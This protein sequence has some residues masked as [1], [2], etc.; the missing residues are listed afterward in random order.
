MQYLFLDLL[1]ERSHLLAVSGAMI[2][3]FRA[4]DCVWRACEGPNIHVGGQVSEEMGC[5]SLSRSQRRR[6]A[7]FFPAAEIVSFGMMYTMMYY[8]AEMVLFGMM[9][10]GLGDVSSKHGADEGCKMHSLCSLMST[11]AG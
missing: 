4:G 2:T 5:L 10:Y 11:E 6:W 1:G 3:A 7:L 9:Y 8:A